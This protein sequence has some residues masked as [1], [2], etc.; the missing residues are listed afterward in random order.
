MPL[1]QFICPACDSPYE[2]ILSLKE[3]ERYG[4]NKRWGKNAPKWVKDYTCPECKKAY[5]KRLQEPVMFRI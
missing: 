5:L 1:Y 2:L 4:N 3:L